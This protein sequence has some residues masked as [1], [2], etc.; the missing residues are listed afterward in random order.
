[1]NKTLTLGELFAALPQK[2]HVST[3]QE[4]EIAGITS[5]NKK[6]QPGH[7]FVTQKGVERDGHQYIPDAVRR[8]AAAIIGEDAAAG[9]ELTVPY[10]VVPNGRETFAHLCAAW[11]GF[12]SR[13]MTGGGH[14][15]H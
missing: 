2:I 6:V 15:R 4:I 14:Y 1:M 13:S 8:G 10:F 7:L 9:D 3:G 12:P 5:H 11:H